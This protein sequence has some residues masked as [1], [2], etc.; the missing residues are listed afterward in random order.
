[1]LD[2]KITEEFY[3]TKSG[4]GCGGYILVRLNPNINGIA[5]MVCPDCKHKHQRYIENGVIK[6]AG[7]TNGKPV[8]EIHPT[9]AAYSK[10]PKTK[11]LKDML[12]NKHNERDGAVVKS[13][14]DFLAESWMDKLGHLL[15]GG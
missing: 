3:C 5:E 7:R 11:I 2:D 8:Q 14:N 12:V 13:A 4:G 9:K 6:E 1:M 10:E 15:T